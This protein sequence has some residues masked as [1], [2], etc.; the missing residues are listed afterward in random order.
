M[1]KSDI[2]IYCM[3]DNSAEVFCTTT[4]E[5][6]HSVMQFWNVFNYNNYNDKMRDTWA[7][8]IAWFLTGR[9]YDIPLFD[10]HLHYEGDLQ[11]TPLVKYLYRDCDFTMAQIEKGFKSRTSWDALKLYFKKLKPERNADIN[12][13]FARCE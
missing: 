5:I 1:I 9:I 7:E 6:A 2:H 12:E 8:G 10:S 13:A 4:H 3:D 11:Y